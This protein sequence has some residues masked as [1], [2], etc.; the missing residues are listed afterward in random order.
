MIALRIFFLKCSAKNVDLDQT[1]PKEQSD[2]V[3]IVCHHLNIY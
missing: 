2:Q 3:C 1:A